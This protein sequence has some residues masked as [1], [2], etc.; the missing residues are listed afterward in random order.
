LS[1]IRDAFGNELEFPSAFRL[2]RR[3]YEPK[4]I[5][6]IIRDTAERP[7]QGGAA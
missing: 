4:G 3:A 5:V 2:S 7:D 1:G 6:R